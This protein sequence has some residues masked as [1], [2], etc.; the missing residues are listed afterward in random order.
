MRVNNFEDLSGQDNI[1]HEQHTCVPCRLDGSIVKIIGLHSTIVGPVVD[2]VDD[3]FDAICLS[4]LHYIV[5]S[6]ETI[7][8]SVNLWFLAD[9]K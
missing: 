7:C 8:S 6:L 1:F 2:K 9:D 5:E 3:E 4:T